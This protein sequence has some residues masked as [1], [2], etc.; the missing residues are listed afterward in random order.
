M[1]YVVVS[2]STFWA[3][4]FANEVELVNKM[5]SQGHEV[6]I[7][8]C[9]G[10]LHL[11][12]YKQQTRSNH[13]CSVCQYSREIVYR[14]FRSNKL[15][16]MLPMENSN[17]DL[18]G[19]V[20]PDKVDDF[21]LYAYDGQVVG[22]PALS[23][24][25]THNGKFDFTTSDH[26]D[27]NNFLKTTIYAYERTYRALKNIGKD[28]ECIL[29]NGRLAEEAGALIAIKNLNLSFW[30]H[31]A[32]GVDE[33]YTLI[34]NSSTHDLIFWHSLARHYLELSKHNEVLRQTGE[35]FFLG[36]RSGKRTNDMVYIKSDY[37][38]FQLPEKHTGKVVIG[39]FNSSDFE[40]RFTSYADQ[41]KSR[42]AENQPSALK[43]LVDQYKGNNNY[44]IVARLHPN[45]QNGNDDDILR[46]T[47]IEAD[48]LIVILP[49][50][51]ISTYSVLDH[52]SF[53]ITSGSTIGVEACYWGH[54][55]ITLAPTLYTSLDVCYQPQSYEE[56]FTLIESSA[57]PR[58]RI[59]AIAIGA[60]LLEH[61]EKR[62]FVSGT[63]PSYTY[64]AIPPQ[65][66]QYSK[67]EALIYCWMMRHCFP[68]LVVVVSC[69][70]IRLI[71]PGMR[72][73]VRSFR[74]MHIQRHHG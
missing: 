38:E 40:V 52:C 27:L 45:M 19:L 69:N 71:T 29:F 67:F 42:F 63:F 14:Q 25:V 10:N 7:L 34:R 44:L 22:Q 36:K 17:I 60:M 56:L 65:Q 16:K 58:S 33:K 2:F 6:T 43:R 47:K 15:F 54:S 73:F 1:K 18:S 32:T 13:A 41:Y 9:T 11:C 37:D 23:T 21:E 57:P 51:K 74:T 28:V 39:F 24:V 31:E 4:F 66:L 35:S 61:G 62:Q 68:K 26:S 70:I 59:D 48:N 30:T 46:Y 12:T 8:H 49:H 53:V 64:G 5:M 72:T 3:N 20:V 50:E 55:V